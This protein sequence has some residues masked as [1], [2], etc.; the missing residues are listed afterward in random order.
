MNYLVENEQKKQLDNLLLMYYLI[1]IV[2]SP[3]RINNTSASALDNFFIDASRYKDFSV[4]P[5]WNDLSDHDAQILTINIPVQKQS[6]R[7]KLIRKMDKHMILDFIFKLSNE[8]WD[9]VFNNNDINLMF[10]SFLN[11]YLKIFYSSFPLIRSKSRNYDNNWVTLGIKM[12]CKR[13][14]ELF[15]LTRNS[16]NSALKQYYKAYC[17]I[18]VKVIKE[19]KRITLNKRILRSNNKTKT[20][21]NIIIELLGKQH[22]TQETQRLTIEGKHLTIQQDIAN[23][24]NNYFST[25]IDKKNS[26]SQENMRHGNPYTY[27][28][29]DHSAGDFYPPLVF[30]TFSTQEITSIIKS[31]K[32]KIYL[33][34]MKLVLNY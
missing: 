21:W 8:S 6:V 34:M 2:N 13:K 22:H 33:A 4:I 3:V 29:F 24:F 28:Y 1:C 17:K 11:T 26:D 14:R 18:L 25:I 10:N 30:K 32:T 23:A 9:G 15:L 5:F 31:I 19:A 7:S 16:N 12:S 27:C 20:T